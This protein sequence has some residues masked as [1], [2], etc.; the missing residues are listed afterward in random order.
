MSIFGSYA[1][2]QDN[3]KEDYYPNGVVK[4]QIP[5]KNR[6]IHGIAKEYY[7]NGEL[8]AKTSYKQ[9]VKDGEEVIYWEFASLIPKSNIL[10][11]NGIKN[12][13]AKYYNSEGYLTKEVVWINGKVSSYQT[14]RPQ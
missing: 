14:F 12:G 11:E 4:S 8:K 6:K 3:L 9:G 2:G 1:A 10:Y 5:Y 7:E 13:T